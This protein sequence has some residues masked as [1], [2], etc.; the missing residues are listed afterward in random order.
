MKRRP[1]RL[2]VRRGPSAE[3]VPAGMTMLTVVSAGSAS[4]VAP[5]GVTAR[6]TSQRP[7]CAFLTRSRMSSSAAISS[8]V[9]ARRLRPAGSVF[10]AESRR[11][12]STRWSNSMKMRASRARPSPSG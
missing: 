12:A 5:P 9:A 11:V 10:K 8:G 2:S 7:F 6:T 3:G 1:C 4:F